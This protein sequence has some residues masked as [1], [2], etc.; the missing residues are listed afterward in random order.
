MVEEGFFLVLEGID[1]SGTT[2]QAALLAERLRSLG[3]KVHVTREPS[4]GPVGRFL[5]QVLSG[6]VPDPM[7]EDRG[8]ALGWDAMALLFSSDRVDHVRREVRPALARGEVVISDRYD[9]SSLIYQSATA[10]EGTAVLSW[11]KSINAQAL[12]PDL[13]LVVDVPADLAE[14]RRTARAEKVEMFEESELQRKLQNFY[15][16]SSEFLPEDRLEVISGVGSPEEVTD[17][18]FQCLFKC[19]EFALSGAEAR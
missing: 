18:L 8:E 7:S 3:R 14:A 10:P 19:P 12:R 4:R 15:M 6:E 5:R 17:R 2:T 16:R 13:T 1:G 11:L 9:L